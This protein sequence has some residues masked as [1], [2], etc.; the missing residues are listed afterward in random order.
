[1]TSSDG[2]S[3]RFPGGDN[4]ATDGQR[5]DVALAQSLDKVGG[6]GF[7]DHGLPFTRRIVNQCAVFGDDAVKYSRLRKAALEIR[8]F[9]PKREHVQMRSPVN[10]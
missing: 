6:W 4:G 9:A 1:M 7:R 5:R 3:M 2:S 8:Q 10:C